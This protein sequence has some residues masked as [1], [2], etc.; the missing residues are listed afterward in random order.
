[1]AS[2]GGKLA[3]L[4]GTGDGFLLQ[5]DCRRRLECHAKINVFAIANPALH[6]SGVVCLCPYC[7]TPHFKWI[8]VLRTAHSRR[9]KPG[10]D[11]KTFGGRYAKH[12]F[13]EVGFELIKNRF[14]NPGRETARNALNHTADRVPFIANLLDERY[15]S[16]RAR[17]VWTAND[18]FLH[19]LHLDSGAINFRDDVVNLRYI[20]DDLEIQVE[21]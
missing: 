20:R 7:S 5:R 18:I 9:R 13:G 1:M 21:R 14:T 6:A 15:H 4:F 2:A 17:G 16:F 3:V 12:G 19:V 10:T 8:I 11:L